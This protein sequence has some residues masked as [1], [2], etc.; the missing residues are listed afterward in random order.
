MISKIEVLPGLLYDLKFPKTWEF[1]PDVNIIFG[2]NGCGKSVF[3]KSIA[4]YFPPTYPKPLE[5]SGLDLEWNDYLSKT[6]NLLEIEYTGGAVHY[7]DYMAHQNTAE[8]F[9]KAQEGDGDFLRW[10]VNDVIK[11]EQDTIIENQ[12][13]PKKINSAISN[14]ARLWFFNNF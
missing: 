7:F 6:I 14:K 5:Y 8:N 3:L 4:H 9:K 10:I 13:D 12:L 1:T 2:P 11:E